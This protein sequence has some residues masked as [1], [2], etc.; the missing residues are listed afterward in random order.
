M[1]L[2][3]IMKFETLICIWILVNPIGIFELATHE[4]D[5]FSLYFSSY[6]ITDPQKPEN[7]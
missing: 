5:A 4:N 3:F 1:E 6:T 2:R 7:L